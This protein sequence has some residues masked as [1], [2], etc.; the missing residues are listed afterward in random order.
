MLCCTL[1]SAKGVMSVE[2]G[3]IRILAADDHPLLRDGI[4]AVIETQA[5]MRLVAEATNGREAIERFRQHIPDITLMDLQMPGISGIEAIASIRNEF[6]Q[7][8]IVVLT[9]YEGDVQALQAFKA[10]ASGYVLK[11][12]VRKELLETIRTVHAGHRRIPP[13][14]AAEIAAHFT[15]DVLSV[16]ELEVLRLA[17]AGGANKTIG[18]QLGIS[19]DTVK[20]HMRSVLAKLDAND[21]T[22][23]VAIAARRGIINL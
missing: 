13:A 12:M 11:S 18:E 22:H 3:P 21:R 19:E 5:D 20:T 10:G 4:A 17:A 7:A 16:R 6:P 8:R 2:S 9:T 15:D 14:V 1:A 23:A